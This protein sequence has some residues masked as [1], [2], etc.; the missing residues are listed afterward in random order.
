MIICGRR[1]EAKVSMLDE[2][3][4]FRFTDKWSKDSGHKAIRS[5]A[6]QR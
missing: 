1:N 5:E 4:G 2:V 6:I 3:D